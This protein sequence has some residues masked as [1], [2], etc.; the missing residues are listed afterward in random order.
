MLAFA[1]ADSKV[2][3]DH[4][5]DSIVVKDQNTMPLVLCQS[6]ELGLAAHKPEAQAKEKRGTSFACASGLYPKIKL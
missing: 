4:L 6:Q 1:T 2:C 5:E 3:L